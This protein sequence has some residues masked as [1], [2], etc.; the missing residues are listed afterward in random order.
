MKIDE[1]KRGCL[2]VFIAMVLI[3]M[4]TAYAEEYPLLTQMQTQNTC[5]ATYAD[6][7][8]SCTPFRCSKSGLMAYGHSIKE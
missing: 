4:P 2:I 6:K 8:A 5:G 3:T 1:C 7:L